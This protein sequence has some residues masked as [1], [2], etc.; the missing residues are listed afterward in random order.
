VLA[1]I[2]KLAL[3]AIEMKARTVVNADDVGAIP[4]S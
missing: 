1:I 4:I 2:M 3:Y